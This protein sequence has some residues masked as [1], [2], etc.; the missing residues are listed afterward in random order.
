MDEQ[1]GEFYESEYRKE[2]ARREEIEKEY[3][4]FRET[5]RQYLEKQAAHAEVINKA[6]DEMNQII[7]EEVKRAK[8]TVVLTSFPSRNLS[9]GGD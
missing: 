1:S 3:A 6:V 7:S 8:D 5:V 2:K 4:E 9:L